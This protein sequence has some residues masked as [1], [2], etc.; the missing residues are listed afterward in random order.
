MDKFR[1]RRHFDF[2]CTVEDEGNKVSHKDVHE[3]LWA[4]RD[5]EINHLWQRSIFLA[6]FITLTFT[7]YFSLVDR[8]ISPSYDVSL[9]HSAIVNSYLTDAGDKLLI[10]VYDGDDLFDDECI[11]ILIL[12]GVST[13]GFAFSILWICMARGSKYMYERLEHG[14]DKVYTNGSGFLD[15][16][17]NQAIEDEFFE[18]LWEPG[19]YSYLPRHGALPLSDY[20]YHL[21]SL[22]GGKFSSSKINIFI[23]HILVTVWTAILFINQII[24]DGSVVGDVQ[25]GPVK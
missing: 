21:Y 15:E 9:N 5:F 16:E 7:L 19:A 23:G 18:N 20:N 2:K 24:V 10:N 14:I 12:N 13:V 25:K 17:L 6:T 8:I 3:K 11:K 22:D 1:Q 4:A